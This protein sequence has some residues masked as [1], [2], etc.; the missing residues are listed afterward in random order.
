MYEFTEFWSVAG[1]NS[2]NSYFVPPKNPPK[3]E[4]LSR[5]EVAYH[6]AG[7]AVVALLLGYAVRYAAIEPEGGG[8]GICL[9]AGEMPRSDANEVVI[10]HAGVI[11]Q[12]RAGLG[13]DGAGTDLTQARARA[14]TLAATYDLDQD[15]LLDSFAALT[16]RV[17]AR[18]RTAIDR[19]A[20]ELLRHRRLSGEDIEY[21]AEIAR[22]QLDILRLLEDMPEGATGEEDDDGEDVDDCG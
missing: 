6:E 19:V 20:E 9:L 8:E 15:A 14:A 16:H 1:V 7:H 10:L 13:C 3:R 2:V 11:A 17:V 22:G 5:T 21:V 18:H 12:Y 4:E